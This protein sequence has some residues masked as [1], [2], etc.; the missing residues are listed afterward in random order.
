MQRELKESDNS[1]LRRIIVSGFALL[2]G[3]AALIAGIFFNHP[4]NAAAICFGIYAFLI[5]ISVYRRSPTKWIVTDD[6][7]VIN[8]MLSIP[9][10]DIFRV[11]VSRRKGFFGTSIYY[12]V[13]GE[14]KKARFHSDI[15]DED[16]EFLKSAIIKAGGR[17]DKPYSFDEF[18]PKL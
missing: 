17:V 6:A 12:Y 13:N 7:F 8:N 5:G 3:I 16:F 18:I 1:P 10:K 2:L 11:V 15:S 9:L 4:P 14:E